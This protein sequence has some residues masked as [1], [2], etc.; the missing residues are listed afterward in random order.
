MKIALRITVAALTAVLLANL[1]GLMARL[2]W[3]LDAALAAAA[4]IAFAYYF[5]RDDPPCGPGP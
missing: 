1:W 5:E 2:S 3:E 4:V